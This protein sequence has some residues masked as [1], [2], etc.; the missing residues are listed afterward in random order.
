MKFKQLIQTINETTL[1]YHDQLNPDLW[2]GLHLKPEV[3][4]KLIMIAHTWASFSKIPVHTIEDVILV[5]GNANYNY[6]NFSDIDLH[7]V[8][9]MDAISDCPEVLQE[10]LKGKKQIW[11]LVH[12]IKVHSHPVELYAQDVKTPYVKGQGVYSIKDH[13]WIVKP[14]K[15][16]VD[17]QNPNIDKKVNHYIDVIETLINSGAEDTAFEKIKEK[18]KNMRSAALKHGGEFSVE[19]LAFKELRNRGYLDK[20][21]KYL[22]TRQDRKLSL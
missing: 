21:T 11:S 18:I 12:D 16:S 10:Y 17:L 20:M 6:T 4:N 2:D 9:D 8:I 3:E 13:K 1:Q 22:Q 14:Q 5:G 15:Q 7:L 19:N